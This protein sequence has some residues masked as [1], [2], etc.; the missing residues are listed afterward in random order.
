RRARSATSSICTSIR[1]RSTYDWRPERA[2]PRFAAAC[3]LEEPSTFLL[4]FQRWS[5][6]GTEWAM[7]RRDIQ[8]DRAWDVYTLMPEYKSPGDASYLGALRRMAMMSEEFG[9]RGM[10]IFTD[11]SQLDP[12]LIAQ[13][14]IESTKALSPL[15]AVQPIYMH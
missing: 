15:V 5:Y 11:N 10:L 2:R 8:F 9:C 12:W 7:M 14:V 1:R 4:R 3:R 13:E 6:R